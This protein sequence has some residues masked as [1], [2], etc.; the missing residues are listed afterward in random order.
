MSDAI[1]VVIADD[2]PMFR[3]GVVMSLREQE[4]IVVV[5]E[6]ADGR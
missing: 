4:G 6:A 1:R 2:H 5:G 3:A